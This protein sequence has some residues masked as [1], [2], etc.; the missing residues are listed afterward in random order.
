MPSEDITKRVDELLRVD[1][2]DENVRRALLDLGPEARELLQGYATGSHPSG[3]PD[4]QGR[5]ILTLGE[6][7]D[8][9]LAVAAL[10][11][12]MESPDTDIRVRA[13]R[14]LGRVG[15][16]EAT[17]LLTAAVEQAD[18][19]DAERTHGIRALGA[20]ATPQARASLEALDKKRLAAPMA[21]ELSDT[22]DQMPD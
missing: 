10:E 3:D 6:S 17:A 1:H 9:G 18:L 4:I 11:K 19:P 16:P 8:P 15:G 7:H 2:F 21:A 14:S 22:L 5:A 13:M 20:I 12:A